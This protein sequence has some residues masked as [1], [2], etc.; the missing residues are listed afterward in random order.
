METKNQ[1]KEEEE[2]E[3]CASV[4]MTERILCLTCFSCASSSDTLVA[5]F[6]SCCCGRSW[7]RLGNRGWKVHRHT[8]STL[9]FPPENISHQRLSSLLLLAFISLQIKVLQRKRCSR[10][11]LA[12]NGQNS[13]RIFFLIR[14]PSPASNFHVRREGVDATTTSRDERRSTSSWFGS[15]CFTSVQSLNPR[16]VS[17]FG[18]KG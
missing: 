17:L 16:S 5:S 12:L 2:E 1:E 13:C 15:Y 8:P 6:A 11:L 7:W 4:F 3:D 9:V 18:R 10:I 14:T